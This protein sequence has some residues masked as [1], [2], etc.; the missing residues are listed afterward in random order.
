MAN[1]EEMVTV[2]RHAVH[3]VTNVW[4]VTSG[5]LSVDLHQLALRRVV[6]TLM[7]NVEELVT[8]V[9][10][11]VLQDINVLMEMRI[12]RNACLVRAQHQP[13]P[14]LQ[15][16]LQLLHLPLHPHQHQLL[17]RRDLVQTEL[18]LNV[19]DRIF[20]GLGVAKVATR[21]SMETNGTVNVNQAPVQHPHRPQLLHL[22]P[23]QLQPQHPH[24]HLLHRQH[25]LHRRH[26]HQVHSTMPRY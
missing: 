11:V 20:K 5:I 15:P 13:Q 17:P 8:L 12:T 18:G 24:Q 22:H 26:L 25:N 19:M 1:V 6:T 4:P 14:Q 21:V 7:G 3:L 2:V 16:P 10:L 9:P 23:H